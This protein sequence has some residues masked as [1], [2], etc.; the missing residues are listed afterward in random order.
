MQRG[1]CSSS[2][3]FQRVGNEI[4]NRKEFTFEVHGDLAFVG[5]LDM[6][7]SLGWAASIEVGFGMGR[8]EEDGVD[9]GG[10]RELA[11]FGLFLGAGLRSPV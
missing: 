9:R 8:E 11:R 6:V 2:I 5:M 4:S 7:M 10:V 3:P 1:G